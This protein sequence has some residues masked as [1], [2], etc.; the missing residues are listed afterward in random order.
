MNALQD[1]GTS[2]QDKY[3]VYLGLWTNWSRGRVM[4]ATLTLRQSDANLLIAFMAFFI[5]LVASRFWRI[6]CFVL[7]RLYSTPDAQD[8][9][10]HQR[11]AILR[12]SSSPEYGTLL[13]L[14]LLWAGRYSKRPLRP[15]LA[16]SI[17]VFC[18][19]AFTVAGGFSSRIS[20]AVGNEVLLQSVNCGQISADNDPQLRYHYARI[21]K[22]DTLNNAANYAQQCYQ[23]NTSGLFD[24]G[25]FVA[26][27]IS[28]HINET[29]TCPFENGMCRKSSSNLQLDTGYVDSHKDLGLNAPE[30][31]RILW[32]N[33]VHCSPLITKGFT[34][35]S[36]TPLGNMTFYHYGKAFALRKNA[37]YSAK[38]VQAQ[39]AENL[40]PD[41]VVSTGNY[42]L[43]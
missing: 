31:E 4:G 5:A 23:N 40:S 22:A 12:N 19:G 28:G 17:A 26:Q 13:L 16:A 30:N 25:R 9:V 8:V 6:I 3:P 37:T 14:R 20:T 29:A 21:F 32:R 42:R 18:M 10:Y 35:N 33:V 36:I 43:E 1:A 15:L 38:S 11:Q 39:I 2:P 41:T 27:R 7:H 24:C 34:S